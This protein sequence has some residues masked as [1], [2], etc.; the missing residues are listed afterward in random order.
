MAT[1]GNKQKHESKNPAQRALLGH[2]KAQ[3]V[4]LVRE[5]Q[6]RSVLEVGCGEGYM[7][8]ALA[9]ADLGIDL[10][11]VD[12]S[13]A[14]IADARARLGSRATLEVLDARQLVSDGRKFDLVVM[15]EVLEHIPR[16]A[17]MLP[18]LEQLSKQHL[19][20]SVPWEPYFRGLNFLR[21]KHI[22]AFG[23]DPEH[24]NHW[25]RGG[26]LEF[27]G[28]RF[29]ILEKPFV[30]PWTMALARLRREA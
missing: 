2:F 22:R 13:E 17:E 28:T 26:F 16:P 3:A 15:V 9:E 18:I 20:L 14:A 25:G 30:F 21:G 29:E 8:Q 27:V 4:R 24:I 11:G 7:L 5:I 10:V 12:I 23:N 1:Y 6:P 19:L